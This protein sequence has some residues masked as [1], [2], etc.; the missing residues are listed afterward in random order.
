MIKPELLA[1]AGDLERLKIAYLYGADA[2]YIGGDFNLRA[3]ADNFS[4]KE[5][6]EA[7]LYAHALNKKIYVT[8]NIAMH[9]K[10][11]KEITDY[12]RLM[13]S[14]LVIQLLLK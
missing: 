7:A 8:V 9:N 14:L 10:E 3:N 13:V 12:L 4:L 1:P 2:V 11:Y 6:K 5:I